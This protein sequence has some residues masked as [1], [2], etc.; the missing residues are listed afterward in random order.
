MIQTIVAALMLM[1][2]LQTRATLKLSQKQFQSTIAPVI[3]VDQTKAILITFVKSLV[4]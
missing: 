1:S 3:E 4:A 2:L